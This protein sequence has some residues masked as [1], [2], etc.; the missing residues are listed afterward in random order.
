MQKAQAKKEHQ[1]KQREKKKSFFFKS[2]NARVTTTT[3][4][5]RPPHVQYHEVARGGSCSAVRLL[6]N[7]TYKHHTHA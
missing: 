3:L 1:H 5:S 7:I 4:N 6:S 2:L